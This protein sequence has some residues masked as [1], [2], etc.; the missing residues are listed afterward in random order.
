MN[1]DDDL[2]DGSFFDINDEELGDADV[3]DQA[4]PTKENATGSRSTTPKRRPGE[5]RLR[6]NIDVITHTDTGTETEEMT[7]GHN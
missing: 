7:D 1:R 3:E 2:Y 5:R 4:V 6:R